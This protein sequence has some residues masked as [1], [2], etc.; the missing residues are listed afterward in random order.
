M[1]GHPTVHSRPTHVFVTRRITTSRATRLCV[2]HRSTLRVCTIVPTDVP[3]RRLS[4]RADKSVTPKSDDD[5]QR[6]R[7]GHRDGPTLPEQPTLQVCSPLILPTTQSDPCRSTETTHD[8]TPQRRLPMTSRRKETSDYC[9]TL[10][11]PSRRCKPIPILSDESH[12]VCADPP[13]S[14]AET[15]RM[16]SD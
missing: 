9:R 14:P 13:D 8:G 1:P 6:P 16:T 10:H 3:H 15:A 2:A 4:C 12:H 5:P 11:T 7:T